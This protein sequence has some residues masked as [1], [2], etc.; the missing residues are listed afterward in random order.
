VNE[1]RIPTPHIV[2]DERCTPPEDNF[3]TVQPFLRE[4][5]LSLE[6]LEHTDEAGMVEKE[7]LALALSQVTA[8]NILP[9]LVE[10]ETGDDMLNY[11]VYLRDELDPVLA[12]E[13]GMV[14]ANN[15]RSLGWEQV[16]E[17]RFLCVIGAGVAACLDTTPGT[18]QLELRYASDLQ[19][20]MFLAGCA[21]DRL[22]SRLFLQTALFEKVDILLVQLRERVWRWL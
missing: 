2:V 5:Y 19:D 6:M 15:W 21:P 1:F 10:L 9:P 18:E 12:R 14:L 17:Y 11:H 7:T 16:S 3:G 20:R 13:L 8:A 22:R 4:S